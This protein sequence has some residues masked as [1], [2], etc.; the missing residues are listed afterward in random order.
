MVF[1][2]QVAVWDRHAAGHVSPDSAV[3]LSLRSPPLSAWWILL[4]SLGSAFLCPWLA[5]ALGHLKLLPKLPS[6]GGSVAGQ[7]ILAAFSSSQVWSMDICQVFGL[8]VHR[9]LTSSSFLP[10]W[11]EAFL[12][13]DPP[14]P[15]VCP[16]GPLRALP[17]SPITGGRAGSPVAALLNQPPGGRHGPCFCPVAHSPGA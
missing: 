11:D 2:S 10:S 12:F 9:S 4:P 16:Q 5:I 1:L 17:Q 13:Q 15:G 6:T 3:L 8:G 7:P 14:Y